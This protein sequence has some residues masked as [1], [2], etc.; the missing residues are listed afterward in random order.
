MRHKQTQM[1]L[2]YWR[3]MRGEQLAPARSSI[4]PRDIKKHLAFTF[5]L[6]REGADRFSFVL[7]GTGVCDLFG[8]ELR[9]SSFSHLFADPSR[10]AATTALVRTAHLS[11]PTVASCVAE[12][13]DGR[14]LTAEVLLLPYADARGET[15]F[16][17]GYFQA[18]EPLSR[19]YG[20]QLVRMRL[21]ASAILTG[22]T[23]VSADAAAR[24][25]RKGGAQLRLVS[26]RP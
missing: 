13:A 3:R 26:A 5:L 7:A 8:R 15:S 9:G 10:D 17:L 24:D 6:K 23:Q 18:L 12:T 21:G 16:V 19:L 2:N 11:V 25:G 20:R 4:A 1:L 22:D 14:P